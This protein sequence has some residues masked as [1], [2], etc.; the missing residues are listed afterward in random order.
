MVT[1]FQPETGGRVGRG[2]FDTWVGKIKK[3]ASAA[4]FRGERGSGGAFFQ[5]AD[6]AR[7]VVELLVQRG[8]FVVAGQAKGAD[9]T[10]RQ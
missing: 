7:Q 10:V 2:R 3:A 4:F 8:H 6:L 5:L 9:G 1:D